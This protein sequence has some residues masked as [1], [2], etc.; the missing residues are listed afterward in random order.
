MM[1]IKPLADRVLVELLEGKVIAVG[2]GKLDDDG[3]APGRDGLSAGA[4][5][6]YGS[7]KVH[8]TPA[9]YADDRELQEVR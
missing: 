8:G 3:N 2:P 1:K 5:E 6:C 4:E 9:R 7:G